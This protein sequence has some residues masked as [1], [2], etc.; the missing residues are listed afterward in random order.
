MQILIDA[1][2]D[3][4]AQNS[5]AGTAPLHCAVK[6]TLSSLKDTH[7]RRLQ[8]VALLMEAGADPKLCDMRGRDAFDS[9]DDAIQE[10]SMRKM[11]SI[12]NE[13]EQMR[14]V[15]KSGALSS[16]S[17]LARCIQ[18]IDAEGV[19]ENLG[20]DGTDLSKSLRAA[21]EKFKLLI[22]EGS[23]DNGAAS[24]KDIM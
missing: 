24:L 3:V 19:K 18:E 13:M 16:M 21:A 2:A 6:G 15:L 17:P 12:E 7:S 10:A 8:C 20:G 23:C 4:N 1:G 22:D 11:G 14:Q 5:I 9:V